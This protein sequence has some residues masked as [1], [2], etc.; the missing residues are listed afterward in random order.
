MGFGLLFIGYFITYLGAFVPQ[1]STF[2]YILGAGVILFSLRKLIYENKLFI[3]SASVALLLEISSII[4]LGIQIFSGNDANLVA[5]ILLY[6]AHASAFALNVLLMLSIMLLAKEVE[7]KHLVRMTL[8]NTAF[9]AI[10]AVLFI[11][12]EIVTNKDVLFG[13]SVALTAVK[14][15]YS[16]FSLVIIFNSYMRICYEGDEKMQK[17]TTGVPI[18][19]SLNKLTD[20]IF[21]KKGK[22]GKK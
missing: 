6:V 2:T 20:K 18:L 21:S 15:I 22:G 9:V 14:I 13:L 8:V 5:T 12:C 19:D 10:G 16:V 17:S 11:P 4:S 7:L 3:A 1:I